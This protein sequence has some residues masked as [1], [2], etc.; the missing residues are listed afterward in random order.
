MAQRD[1]VAYLVC[2]GLLSSAAVVDG[3]VVVRDASRRNRNF[4]VISETTTSYM[5]KQRIGMSGMRMLAHEASAYRR[6][7][8]LALANELGRYVP[9]FHGYD[10]ERDIIIL[11]LLPEAESLLD[12]Q[13]N[14]GRF[15]T[16]FA[17]VLGRALGALHRLPVGSEESGVTG[18]AAWVLSV[19]RPWLNDLRQISNANLELIKLLQRS[20]EFC[21]LLD[22]LR[23]DWH[24]DGLIH[25]D[26]KGDNIVAFARSHS[27]RKTG[28]AIVDWENVGPGDTCW[29]A[30]SVFGDYLTLWFLSM[31]ITGEAPPDQFMELARYPLEK[32]QPA[33]QAFW[34]A[35]IDHLGLDAMESCQRLIRAVRYAAAR[36]VQTAFEQTQTS[37]HL[38]GNVICLLQLSLNILQRPLEASVHLLG[39]KPLE[40]TLS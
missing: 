15:P 35:Y 9:P 38:E 34:F 2:R 21:S 20:A 27:G 36:L 11:G 28:L 33:M 40:P 4:K 26:I 3:Q 39:I 16:S 23:K 14:R 31:P 25:G 1:V 37:V 10:E 30:G 32:L 29:D 22:H 12:Y 24:V 7:H 19:H 6:F 5:L 18:Q 17:K 13:R 8:S